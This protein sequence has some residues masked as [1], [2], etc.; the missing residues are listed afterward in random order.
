MCNEKILQKVTIRGALAK[1]RDSK[2]YMVIANH[3]CG[4]KEVY[5]EVMRMKYKLKFTRYK[6]CR[7]LWTL[8][9]KEGR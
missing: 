5:N 3:V 7:E 4:Y 1:H 6:S 2:I 9:K 8:L